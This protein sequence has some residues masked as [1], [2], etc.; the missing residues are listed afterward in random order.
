[1][2][3]GTFDEQLYLATFPDLAAKVKAGEYSSGL[4]YYTKVGQFEG[5]A[6][7]EGFFTGTPGN[8]VVT[9]FGS[10][11]DLFGVGYEDISLANDGTDTIDPTVLLT[12]TSLGVGEVDV[13]LGSEG[14]N[15][16]YLFAY[17]SFNF[18]ALVAET[19]PLYV[20]EGDQDY[21]LIK[22]LD[23]TNGYVTISTRDF[24]E[25]S[26]KVDGQG[27][28]IYYN[29]DLIG[30][31]E[32]VYDLQVGFYFE[33]VN[34]A[35]LSK[36]TDSGVATGGFNEAAY[37]NIYP[38]V[39]ELL[40]NG[41]FKSGLEHYA[42]VGQNQK[43]EDDGELEPRA[44]I[45]TGTNGDDVVI[46]YGRATV[47]SGVNFEVVDPATSL[48]LKASSTGEGEVDMLI[49]QASVNDTFMMGLFATS[50][51]P[52][53]EKFYVG[54]GDKDYATIKNFG[55]ED[56]ILMVGNPEDYSFE[57]RDGNTRVSTIEGDLVAIAAGVTN[58]TVTEIFAEQSFFLVGVASTGLS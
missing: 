49:G 30:I 9:G 54:Q 6:L 40:R 39:A 16:N 8:D 23:P 53:I 58:A 42:Q 57:V 48:S 4:E 56:S 14:F 21:A 2:V 11:K 47:L 34:F 41:G 24:S 36:T 10:D 28:K 46:G 1:M 29:D 52:T 25:Y 37:L 38:E 32:G 33:S 44:A 55:D 22:N 45:F 12:P 35:A 3:F 31:V 7:T 15:G 43:I 5:E 17:K 19:V 50:A 20:G 26:Y 51:C 13:L 18:D 27:F